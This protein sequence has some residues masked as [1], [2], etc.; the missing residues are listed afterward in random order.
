MAEI[1]H[2][3]DASFEQDVVKSAVPVLVKFWSP[4]CDMC[5]AMMKSVDDLAEEYSDKIKVVK[6]NVVE[7]REK[8]TSLGLR[9]IPTLMIWKNGESVA[10]NVGMMMRGRLQQFIDSAI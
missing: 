4:S 5:K 2:G 1:I 3:T 8:A 10:L 6:I 7:N 9:G